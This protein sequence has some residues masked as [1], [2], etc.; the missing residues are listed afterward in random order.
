MDPGDE[1]SFDDLSVDDLLERGHAFVR[2]CAFERAQQVA[3]KLEARRHTGAFEVGALARAGLG[4]LEDA[5]AYLT[6]GLELAPDVWL[7]WQLLGNYQSD[8]ERYAEASGAY[9]RALAC[10]NAWVGSIRLNQALL[11]Y[12][13]GHA[14]T[15]IELLSKID[16]AELRT[17][18]ADAWVGALLEKG[19]FAAA[20][21]RCQDALDKSPPNTDDDLLARLHD[22][23]AVAMRG[24]GRSK[25]DVREVVLRGLGHDPCNAGLHW[26]L[27]ELDGTVHRKTRLYRLLLLGT[28]ERT[29]SAGFF[30]TY[31]V[32]ARSQKKAF[33][34]ARI[35][36]AA[37]GFDTLDIH[38]AEDQ[39]AHPDVHSGV[40]ER[41]GRHY[42]ADDDE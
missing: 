8:L 42:F 15:A 13:Q 30:V 6:R 38:E 11:A 7:N 37:F 28:D 5:I 22:Q 16:D 2:S 17:R 10:P 19:E 27:R 32:A 1:L 33:A 23:L 36:E 39:G 9:E 25:V 41:G 12:R 14:D 21:S 40:Y 18:I 24:V 34:S 29:D 4:N 35:V 3:D 26:L 20:E 31:V